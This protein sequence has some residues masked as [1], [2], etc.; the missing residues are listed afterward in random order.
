MNVIL[1]L[2]DSLNRHFLE[3]YGCRTVATP[4]L[5]AFSERATVFD[6]HF[7]GS[8]PCMPARRELFT[9]R[10]EFLWRPWGHLEPFDDPISREARRAGAVTAMITD[11]YHYWE[12]GAHGYFEEFDYV[13]FLRGHE[14]AWLPPRSPRRFR[15]GRR[16]SARGRDGRRGTRRPIRAGL[17]TA[18]P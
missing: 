11:H 4:N 7:I 6:Q 2:I 9:G 8:A 5:K 1:L 14:L 10:Q 16:P 12:T 3:T 13:D 18:P 17:P 15:R